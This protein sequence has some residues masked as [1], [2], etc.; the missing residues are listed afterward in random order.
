MSME[1]KNKTGLDIATQEAIHGIEMKSDFLWGFRVTADDLFDAHTT[2]VP[3]AWVK[4]LFLR[5][6]LGLSLLF[7]AE[8]Q[9][10]F[11]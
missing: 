7:V 3:T 5:R 10:S 8:S 9:E 4:C 6:K 2:G 1:S 11:R